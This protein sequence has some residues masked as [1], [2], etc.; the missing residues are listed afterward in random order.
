MALG[1]LVKEKRIK[2]G[3]Q[4]EREREFVL[5]KNKNKNKIRIK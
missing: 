1:F 4:K 3:T 2:K 5:I